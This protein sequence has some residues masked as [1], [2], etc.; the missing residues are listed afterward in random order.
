MAGSDTDT[1]PGLVVAPPAVGA[2]VTPHF[3]RPKGAALANGVC[4]PDP[5]SA[6][7]ALFATLAAQVAHTL[8]TVY[9]SH[10]PAGT[11]DNAILASCSGSARS[12]CPF[13][14]PTTCHATPSGSPSCYASRTGIGTTC[15]YRPPCGL[16]HPFHSDHFLGLGSGRPLVSASTAAQPVCSAASRVECGPALPG[17]EG[18]AAAGGGTARTAPQRNAIYRGF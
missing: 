5:A 18:G 14:T 16:A 12:A 11:G 4:R 8:P 1:R 10:H 9:R 2:C 6:P 17:A 3:R 7:A 15:S 13:P